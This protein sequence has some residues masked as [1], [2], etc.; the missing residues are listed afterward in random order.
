S[1]SSL[2]SKFH[3]LTRLAGLPFLF[4]SKAYISTPFTNTTSRFILFFGVLVFL[5]L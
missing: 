2:S 1:R 3:R 4:T 5:C